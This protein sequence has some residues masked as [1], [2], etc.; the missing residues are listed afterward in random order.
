MVNPNIWGKH[1]WKFLHYVSLG[2]PETPTELQKKQYKNF[3]LNVGNILPCYKCSKNYYRHLKE[4]PLT[5]NILS[6]KE[7]FKNWV[8]SL[9]NAVN[10]ENGKDIVSFEEAN[11]LIK[12]NTCQVEYTDNKQKLDKEESV[13]KEKLVDK[14]TYIRNKIP[15]HKKENLMNNDNLYLIGIIFVSIIIFL[16]FRFKK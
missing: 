9:H 16:I 13:D 14:E 8:I 3:Y 4:I 10:I 1:G 12:D 7:Y 5:D 11:I 15:I 6:N 2:Y